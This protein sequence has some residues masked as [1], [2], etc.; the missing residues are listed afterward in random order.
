[1][2]DAARTGEI[3]EALAPDS[4]SAFRQSIVAPMPVWEEFRKVRA[5][6]TRLSMQL[7]DLAYPIHR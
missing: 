7:V 4:N 6:W 5:D 2:P 1:M 3:G